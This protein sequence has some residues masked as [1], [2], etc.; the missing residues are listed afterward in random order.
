MTKFLVVSGTWLL[1]GAIF[2]ILTYPDELWWR[3][4]SFR[5]VRGLIGIALIIFG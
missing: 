1:A 3:N 2:S 5:I 4:Y